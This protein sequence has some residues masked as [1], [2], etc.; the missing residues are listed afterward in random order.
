M[1][2]VAGNDGDQKDGNGSGADGAMNLKPPQDAQATPSPSISA[3]PTPMASPYPSISPSPISSHHHDL[4]YDQRRLSE[5]ISQANGHPSA[6]NPDMSMMTSVTDGDSSSSSMYLLLASQ[7]AKVKNL[8]WEKISR[9][10]SLCPPV[11]PL[12]V[13]PHLASMWS[14]LTE[15]FEDAN[16][17]GETTDED[18]QSSSSD[19]EDEKDA[20]ADGLGAEQKGEDDDDE[21]ANGTKRRGTNSSTRF[22]FPLP[23]LWHVRPE[24]LAVV[25]CVE[26]MDERIEAVKAL[27]QY[28]ILKQQQRHQSSPNVTPDDDADDGHLGRLLPVILRFF[29]SLPF[30]MYNVPHHHPFK[31]HHLLAA[32][33]VL[34]REVAQ[35]TPNARVFIS[36]AISLMLG[37][38][39]ERFGAAPN[40]ALADSANASHTTHPSEQH[41]GAVLDGLLNT[42]G[43][44]QSF[45]WTSDDG[46]RIGDILHTL[47]L[48]KY[49]LRRS[50]YSLLLRALTTHMAHHPHVYEKDRLKYMFDH[51]FMRCTIQYPSV[52]SAS[53]ESTDDAAQSQIVVQTVQLGVLIALITRS[54]DHHQHAAAESTGLKANVSAEEEQYFK[55]RTL[56]KFKQMLDQ[57]L[58]VKV[59]QTGSSAHTAM[60][61]ASMSNGIAPTP[62]PTPSSP[63]APTPSPLHAVT[64]IGCIDIARALLNGVVELGSKYRSESMSS[65]PSSTSTAR[66]IIET[67]KSILLGSRRLS[68]H[69]KEKQ[70]RFLITRCIARM[71]KLEVDAIQEKVLERMRNVS[72][73]SSRSSTLK[74]GMV[75]SNSSQSIASVQQQRQITEPIPRVRAAMSLSV[76]DAKVT[77]S[78]RIHRSGSSHTLPTSKNNLS[79]VLQHTRTPSQAHVQQF[80]FSH[81]FTRSFVQGLLATMHKETQTHTMNATRTGA[82][83]Q[84]VITQSND[85]GKDLANASLSPSGDAA[86]PPST[87]YQR[88]L[89]LLADLVSQVDYAPLTHM[90]IPA[91]LSR[92]SSH[93]AHIHLIIHQLAEVAVLCERRMYELNRSAKKALVQSE[94]AADMQI[95]EAIITLFLQA[96]AAQ[97]SSTITQ[98]A[99]AAGMSMSSPPASSSS[100]ISFA[101]R[102]TL[103]ELPSAFHRLASDFQSPVLK[104]QLL[105]RLLKLVVDLS[106]EARQEEM[107]AAQYMAEQAKLR[108]LQRPTAQT[109]PTGQAQT[110]M[111][112]GDSCGFLLPVLATLMRDCY[113]A[114]RRDASSVPPQ[115]RPIGL[116][117]YSNPESNVKWFRR[118]WLFLTTFRFTEGVVSSSV[119]AAMGGGGA[120]GS[121]ALPLYLSTGGLLAHWNES[122]HT[123]ALYSPILVNPSNTSD[124]LSTELVKE[125]ESIFKHTPARSRPSGSVSGLATGLDSARVAKIAARLVAS[126]QDACR[127]QLASVCPM[128]L[129]PDISL[130]PIGRVLFLI[131]VFHLEIIR[132]RASCSMLVSSIDATAAPTVTLTHPPSS[133]HTPARHDFTQLDRIHGLHPLFGY[134]AH[135]N[136]D[137]LKLTPYINALGESI[138][139]PLVQRMLFAQAN[140]PPQRSVVTDVLIFLLCR[141][142]SRSPVVRSA[143]L[144]IL[145]SL[146]RLQLHLHWHSGALGTLLAL[147]QI[148]DVS[149]DTSI[150]LDES[151][152]LR[153]VISGGFMSHSTHARDEFAHIQAQ[154]D[155]PSD[156]ETRGEIHAC[157]HHLAATWLKTAK[158][159]A[160][161]H[162]SALI[163]EFMQRVQRSMPR[164]TAHA[165]WHKNV[166]MLVSSSVNDGG[167]DST[168]D[169][170][171]G[172]TLQ[173]WSESVLPS[174]FGQLSL[175]ER[176]IGEVKAMYR[177]YQETAERRKAEWEEQQQQQQHKLTSRRQQRDLRKPNI[178]TMRSMSIVVAEESVQAFRHLLGRNRHGA[179]APSSSP[180]SSTHIAHASTSASAPIIPPF[181]CLLTAKLVSESKQL[182]N[183][184]NAVHAANAGINPS[185]THHEH[186]HASAFASAVGGQNHDKEAK[187]KEI[188]SRFDRL[189]CLTAAL[190]VWSKHA[191]SSTAADLQLD[192][193]D[194]IHLLV[195]APSQIFT[196]ASVERAVFTWQWLLAADSSFQLPLII[197][198]KAAWSYTVDRQVGLFAHRRQAK[199]KDLKAGEKKL[200]VVDDDNADRSTPGHAPGHVQRSSIESAPI[201]PVSSFSIPSQGSAIPPHGTQRSTPEPND[202]SESTSTSKQKPSLPPNEP[203]STMNAPNLVRPSAVVEGG[204]AAP[205][206]AAASPDSH[207][208]LESATWQADLA[209]SDLIQPHTIWINFLLAHFHYF[210]AFSHDV[211]T[212]LAAMIHKAFARPELLSTT[213]Q[214]FP[215]RFRLILLGLRL[216]HG[217]GVGQPALVDS[218]DKQM[219]RDRVYAAALDWFENPAIWFDCAT[220]R[221]LR[222]DVHVIL[223]CCKLLTE[224]DAYWAEMHGRTIAAPEHHA[225]ASYPLTIGAV[226][227]VSAAKRRVEDLRDRRQLLLFLLSH[228]LDRIYAWHAPLSPSNPSSLPPVGPFT[229]RR[230][231]YAPEWRALIHTAWSFSPQLC[232]RLCQRFQ[233]NAIPVAEVTKLV[234]AQPERVY[235]LPEAVAYIV[236]HDTIRREERDGESSPL[237]HLIYFTPTTL[238]LAV[239]FLCPPYC[240]SRLVLEYAVQTLRSHPPENVMFYLPQILQCL[241][242]DSEDKIMYKFLLD[243]SKAS[244]LLSH[245]LLWLAQA[246]LGEVKADKAYVPT[247]FRALVSQLIDDVIQRFD[248][249][250]RKFY[251]QEFEFFEQITAISGILKPLPTKAARKAKIKECLLNISKPSPNIYLP[252]NPQLQVVSIRCDSGAPMQSAAKVP[253]LVAFHVKLGELD[254]KCERRMEERRKRGKSTGAAQGSLRNVRSDGTL[255]ADHEHDSCSCSDVDVGDDGALEAADIDLLVE[256]EVSVSEGV[257]HQM[258]TAMER[259]KRAN[260]AAAKQTADQQGIMVQAC[261]FKVGD[262]CRQDA[263]ALQVIQWCKNIMQANGLELFLY[264]YR[265]LPN[266]TGED[267]LVGGVIECVPNA[268]TRDEIGKTMG[269]S[270]KSYYIRRFGPP[271]S[272]AFQRAQ[273][274]FIV[275]CAGYA[276]T[277]YLLQVKDRHNGNLMI[278]KDGHMVHIDFGFIFDISPAKDMRFESAGFKLTL[279]MV[280]LMGSDEHGKTATPLV[281]WFQELVLRGFMAVREHR[282]EILALVEPMLASTLPCFKAN[283]LAALKAR[284]FPDKDE[285]AAAESMLAIVNDAWNKWTTNAYDWIQKAQQNVFY[286]KGTSAADSDTDPYTYATHHHRAA[287]AADAATLTEA[288][289]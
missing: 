271:E 39:A 174:L 113:H 178:Q 53:P 82:P 88:I 204:A 14:D 134:L 168:V 150:M 54:N 146:T 100:T 1:S 217:G 162:T 269:C 157:L 280:E 56:Q 144:S 135:Y 55:D 86:F 159:H 206:D 110:A 149:L 112:K 288:E 38:V 200:P 6:N 2:L 45:P 119:N 270:L 230:S 48:A 251:Q 44:G 154:L 124:F 254:L 267:G 244:V 89:I 256:R 163:Q 152:H 198:M 32:F 8:P 122:I 92:L 104:R 136:L 248:A 221:Q 133:T 196:T 184:F 131:S 238:P 241:R 239:L 284:F 211:L 3:Y 279:E 171:S 225:D 29:L 51:E 220:P 218:R 145:R 50:T 52:S 74:K 71:C 166:H 102:K 266:R 33:V 236:T 160:P 61:G 66:T 101:S 84:R 77:E 97:P 177:S 138:L 129:Q 21:K 109:T 195:S 125:Y 98:H 183:E 57:L 12:S 201:S 219:L 76:P 261:I 90:I 27:A 78:R 18:E 58:N 186:H 147:L 62:V 216:L 223:Q 203:T 132:V 153:S 260:L 49:T 156:V 188:N 187:L 173:R 111:S 31:P 126:M 209:A 93:P 180:H 240:Q 231:M 282:A 41:Y 115:N 242:N 128:L 13:S 255:P 96:Y 229:A 234:Q 7:M 25:E 5:F 283:S 175:K 20:V 79:S 258:K 155:L 273:R 59:E 164:Y 215:C 106:Y 75:K 120:A 37:V 43:D 42:L 99:S 182:I 287:Q 275:S 72:A 63:A 141:L 143:S 139:V 202:A 252:T 246:E 272:E 237:R 81:S 281:K 114:E 268:S 15:M 64:A 16:R 148:L 247:P 265:V 189:L 276:V 199:S 286:F 95:V 118:L 161:A 235:H 46:Q 158:Q 257:E 73:S 176:Y 137:Q 277:S 185:T 23:R 170:G 253:I 169:S 208:T 262:D 151:D 191:H 194:L 87:L 108:K 121:L 226:S 10:C 127:K 278:D 285:A 80:E 250:E 264:P 233:Q 289:E 105:K 30:F 22:S 224:E 36:K 91:V 142:T 60:N 70:L 28:I 274:N 214:S 232:V 245:Q 9:L 107:D 68:R 179:A 213:E 19:E 94:W 4:D 67:M 243:S 116:Q 24:E 181:G 222:A 259:Q 17:T 210:P 11:P 34:L 263:L 190:L 83:Y 193:Q 197:E 167:S 130:L 165:A 65:L 35:V 117:L 212:L 227:S 123:I 207:S 85:G 192:P 103:L 69:P 140:R 47:F 40:S 172:A 249:V 26:S 228:E 205:A